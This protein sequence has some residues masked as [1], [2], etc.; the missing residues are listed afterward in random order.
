MH[1]YIYK[2]KQISN[3]KRNSQTT[4]EKR[5]QQKLWYVTGPGKQPRKQTEAMTASMLYVLAWRR[6]G[7]VGRHHDGW[8]GNGAVGDVHLDLVTRAGVQA[9]H[10]EVGTCGGDVGEQRPVFQVNLRRGKGC[11]REGDL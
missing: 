3:E 7:G 11:M 4:P 1:T 10:V 6:P 9:A 8:G 5:E 2:N